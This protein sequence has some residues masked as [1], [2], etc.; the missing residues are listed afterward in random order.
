MK[1]QNYFPSRIADQVLWLDNFA[2]R[3]PDYASALGL[4]TPEVNNNVDDAKWA[5]YVLGTWITAARGFARSATDTVNGVLNGSGSSA[6]T[7]PTFT[8]PALPSGVTAQFPGVLTR[9]YG[10]VSQIKRANGY[11]D[12]IG[13]DLGV[14][15]PEV[16]EKPLKFSAILEQGP[17]CQCVRLAFFKY[18]HTGVYIETKRGTG[19]WEH[20]GIDTESP[21]MDERPLAVAGVP[22]IR[23]YRMRFWDKGVANGDWTDVATVTVSP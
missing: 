19:D 16:T 6:V 11:T 8:P 12:S 13:T 1:R 18:T 14:V 20:L 3:L 5:S 10:F 15:G 17:D 22:E 2:N 21:Y 4:T 23:A 9:I 7:L